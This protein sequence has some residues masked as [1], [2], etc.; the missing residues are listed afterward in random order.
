MTSA[1]YGGGYACSADYYDYDPYAYADGYGY[2]C[3]DSSD[4]GSGFASIGFGGGWYDDYYYPGYGMW[5]Y[6]NYRN[7]HPLR[8]LSGLLGRAARLVEASRRPGRSLERRQEPRSASRSASAAPEPPRP[9]R[10]PQSAREVE[11]ARSRSR[12][13]ARS[14]A[15]ARRRRRSPA[16]QIGR[17]HV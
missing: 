16:G 8:P 14:C 2:D 13:T 9:T 3:Y 5:M 10:S 6:D 11:R 15:A 17:A 4:D 1:G 12:R 7:R